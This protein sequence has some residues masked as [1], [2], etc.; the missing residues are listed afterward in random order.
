MTWAQ[1]PDS[2]PAAIEYVNRQYGFRFT[3]PAD[4]AGYTIVMRQWSGDGGKA[5]IR[6]PLL[7]FRNPHWTKEDPWEDIPIMIFTH[8]QWRLV[9][10][11]TLNV[12]GAAPYGP[13]EMGRNRKYVFA[14]PPRFSSDEN[15]G[16]R[17]V[18]D[19]VQG[20]PLHAF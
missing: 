11:G 9:D 1:A 10:N 4:W 18:I 2:R 5:M 6:G 20:H 13:G 16:F 12:S 14:L 17:E 8:Q 3:L 15:E 7:F 19:I